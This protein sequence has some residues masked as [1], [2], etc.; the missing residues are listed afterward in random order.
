MVNCPAVLCC[1]EEKKRG[2]INLRYIF[3]HIRCVLIAR[4]GFLE[5]REREGKLTTGTG[6]GHLKNPSHLGA[7][8]PVAGVDWR[9]PAE[10]HVLTQTQKTAFYPQP[11]DGMEEGVANK[12]CRLLVGPHP[13]SGS[14]DFSGNRAPLS[15]SR[16]R[17]FF[18]L[19]WTP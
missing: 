2:Y 13:F 15:L 11:H 19:F 3:G 5:V 16:P 9:H 1:A 14:Y 12:G 7:K 6:K 18:S 17:I 10:L 8:P 4:V